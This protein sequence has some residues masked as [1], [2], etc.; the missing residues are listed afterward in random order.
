[1]LQYVRN[2]FKCILVIAEYSVVITIAKNLILS[3]NIV[4]LYSFVKQQIGISKDDFSDK[5]K[6]CTT[7]RYAYVPPLLQCSQ[8]FPYV[9][10]YWCIT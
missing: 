4:P 9:L 5:V 7:L 6:D 8:V 3:G 2:L 10:G 1:M